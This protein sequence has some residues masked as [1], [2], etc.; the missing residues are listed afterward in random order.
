[1]LDLSSGIEEIDREQMT[2]I[3]FYDRSWKKVFQD[4]FENLDPI[5]AAS[6]STIASLGQLLKKGL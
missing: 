4:V 2:T 5:L 1:M 3:S 6:L